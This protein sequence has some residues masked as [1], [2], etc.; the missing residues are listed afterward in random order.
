M[1][2]PAM[3]FPPW[4]FA[5]SVK[6]VAIESFSGGLKE[7]ANLGTV[8]E[9]AVNIAQHRSH[10]P[11]QRGRTDDGPVDDLPAAR[12]V[13]G[14]QAVVGAGRCEEWND[15]EQDKNQRHQEPGLKA[16]HATLLASYEVQHKRN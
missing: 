7:L 1:T 8:A 14:L 16:I 2:M 9:V 11:L 6:K 12:N 15:A 3:R 10:R 5:V 13:D 4:V